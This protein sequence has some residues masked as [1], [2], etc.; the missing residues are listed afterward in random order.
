GPGH[1]RADG[2]G[3]GALLRSRTDGAGHPPAPDL[4]PRCPRRAR[5]GRNRARLVAT[6]AARRLPQAQARRDRPARGPDAGGAGGALRKGVLSPDFAPMV[7]Q[8]TDARRATGTLT[9]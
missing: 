5:G 6:A 8:R 4:A 7:G 3:P 2:G 9:F 1:A